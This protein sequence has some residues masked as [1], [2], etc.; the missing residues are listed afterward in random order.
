[1]N[2]LSTLLL[3]QKKSP[4][5]YKVSVGRA[6]DMY[7]VFKMETSGR[8]GFSDKIYWG[9]Y[10]DNLML[11]LPTLSFTSKLARAN[12]TCDDFRISRKRRSKKITTGKQ[13][14][15]AACSGTSSLTPAIV[16]YLME[17]RLFHGRLA[18]FGTWCM[19][20]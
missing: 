15:S 2:T 11:S 1:M 13:L 19:L 8:M 18:L 12:K 6:I 4:I 14:A 16:Q 3:A 9:Y 7:F 10:F 17:K 5:Q 20:Y